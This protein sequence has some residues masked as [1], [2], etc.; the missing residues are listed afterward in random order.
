MAMGWLAVIQ[1]LNILLLNHHFQNGLW[2]RDATPSL[3]QLVKN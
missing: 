3:P 2:S 1:S